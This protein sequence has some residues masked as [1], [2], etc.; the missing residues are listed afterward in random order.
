[1]I[2]T[3]TGLIGGL[4]AGVLILFW[5]VPAVIGMIFSVIWFLITL[6]FRLL[7]LIVVTGIGG[8]LALLWRLFSG[9]FGLFGIVGA[10][11]KW[12]L[13][14]IGGLFGAIFLYSF[15]K[16]WYNGHSAP[17]KKGGSQ[18]SW[19]L[20]VMGLDDSAGLRDIKKRYRELMKTEH[21]DRL[22]TDATEEQRRAAEERAEQINRAYQI[23][24][25]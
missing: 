13:V 16:S 8:L 3:R 2:S 14:I 25:R 9:F 11:V 20:E 21:P 1:V 18:R 15:F 5:L 4:I 23:L 24:T 10:I 19:A 7:Y 22:G 17:S 12:I 6:P